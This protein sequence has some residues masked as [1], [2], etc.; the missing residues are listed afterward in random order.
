M[1]NIPAM[2]EQQESAKTK[3]YISLVNLGQEFNI[4]ANEIHFAN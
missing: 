1:E 3:E 2:S 4:L